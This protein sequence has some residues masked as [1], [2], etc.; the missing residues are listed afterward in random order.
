MDLELAV[1]E[2]LKVL[3]IKEKK[4]LGDL[5]SEILAFGLRER[6]HATQKPAALEWVAKP[7]KARVDLT[8]K[9]ALYRVLDEHP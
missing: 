1:L 7:M 9:E 6:A 2:Q 3:Q 5:A 4:S 8:D